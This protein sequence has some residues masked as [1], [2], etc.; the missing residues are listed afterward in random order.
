MV[1][2]MCCNSLYI[3]LASS[4]KKRREMTKFCDV[5]LRKPHMSNTPALIRSAFLIYGPYGPLK[6]LRT[7]NTF[8][9]STHFF[10]F[11]RLA[12][13]QGTLSVNGPYVS[14]SSPG[15]HLIKDRAPSALTVRTFRS[16][17]HTER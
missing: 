15:L 16:V 2:H 12:S 11:A 8:I 3:S 6:Q 17:R 9:R 7:V 14:F 4:A 5:S 1:L 13:R 10:Q